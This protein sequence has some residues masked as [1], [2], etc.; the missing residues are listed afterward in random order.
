MTTHKFEINKSGL[1]LK[2]TSCFS[3]IYNVFLIVIIMLRYRYR[4]H[5]Y[6]TIIIQPVLQEKEGTL[7]RILVFSKHNDRLFMIVSRDIDPFLSS[8]SSSFIHSLSIL[9][10]FS[11]LLLYIYIYIFFTF[12]LFH[13]R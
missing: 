4:T 1:S 2:G 9:W 3:F 7:V 10:T 11:F 6:N 5:K 13:F 8:F 12:Y